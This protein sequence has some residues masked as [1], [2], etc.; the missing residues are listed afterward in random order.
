M[1]KKL[2]IGII[3][4]VLVF[5]GRVCLFKEKKDTH[6]TISISQKAIDIYITPNFDDA[7]VAVNPKI[8]G[9]NIGFALGRELDKDSGFVQLLRAMH[10]TSLRF[11]GGTVANYYHPNLP[12]YGYIKKEIPFGLGVLY[13]LQSKRSENIL[14]NYIRLSKLVG[15]GAVFCANLL[16][17]TLEETM[18][19]LDALKKQ[20]IPILGVELGN[21]FNLLPYR[22][23]EFKSGKIY[24]DK[25][26]ATAAAIRHKYPEI[27]IAIV[28]ADIVPDNDKNQRSQ[29]MRS[30]NQQLSEENFYDAYVWHFYA[31]C[32]SCDNNKNFDQVYVKNLQELAPFKTKK[33]DAISDGFQKIYGNQ[34]KLWLT[35]WNISNTTFLENTFT[36]AAYVY[37]SFLKM[38]DINIQQNNYIEISHLQAM[39][40]LIN[41]YKGKMKALYAIDGENATMQ[42]FAFKYLAETLT[43]DVYAAA[44]QISCSDKAVCDQFLSK[45]FIRKKD[46]TVFIHFINR[47]GN[48]VRLHLANNTLLN[49]TITSIEADVPY[50]TI[51]KTVYEKDYPQKV[52]PAR[53]QQKNITQNNIEIAPYSLGYIAYKIEQK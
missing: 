48:K 12:V 33:L 25:V 8:F 44:Q 9:V 38:I 2:K 14:Y 53:L 21:E 31:N 47:S 19:V 45:T 39:D 34:H 13:N 28:G 17:G 1:H 51:G 3:L 20:H 32:N 41:P 30:W 18:F 50:A 42:Y 35:E 23:K 46:N 52:K 22:E 49:G 37:E 15:S 5:L 29:F 24:A 26:K 10:P 11:P 43:D 36:Q 7:A 40:A 16:T 6:A 27:K 4:I